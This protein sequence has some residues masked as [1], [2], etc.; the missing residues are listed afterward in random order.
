MAPFCVRCLFRRNYIKRFKSQSKN[1]KKHKKG[2]IKNIQAKYEKLA[3]DVVEISAERQNIREEQ[4]RVREKFEGIANECEELK[5][6]TR[7]VV[8]QTARTQIKLALMFQIVKASEQAD[9]ATVSTLTHLLR[10]IVK[11]E[12][13]ERQAS[14]DS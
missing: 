5:R 4:R 8:Q 6:E 7:I 10:E 1:V 13:E 3:S 12:N 14:D 11:R 2:G 9:H